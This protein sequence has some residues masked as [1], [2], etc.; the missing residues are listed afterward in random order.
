VLGLLPAQR[1]AYPRPVAYDLVLGAGTCLRVT[2]GTGAPEIELARAPR[3]LDETQFRVQ[4]DPA[5]L[6]RLLAAG[7]V[8]RRLW[9]GLARRQGERAGFKALQQLTAT[10]FW[11]RQLDAVGVTLDAALTLR[12]AALMIEG[13]AVNEAFSLAHRADAASPPDA[14]LH[15]APGGRA[16]V[17]E[18][19]LELPATTEIV[20]AG[21]AVLSVLLGRRGPGV[22]VRGDER[23]LQLV[24][25]ALERA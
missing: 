1:L 18:L 4:G 6:A 7:P 10:A 20:C 13:A 14:T 8:R 17:S 12:L 23:P 9:R 15:V 16:T 5:G 3:A 2:V 11:P 21:G 22:T 19:G 25:R 24:R